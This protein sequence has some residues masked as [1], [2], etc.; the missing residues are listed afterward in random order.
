VELSYLPG[1]TFEGE[2]TYVYPFL[3]PKTRTA[4]VRIEL[5]N[6]DR[7]LKPDMFANVE[8]HAET[9]QGVL[10][11]PEA[12][13]IRSGRRTLVVVALGEGRFEP[14]EVVLGMDSGDGQLEIRE[15]L[16]ESE[17]IVTSGQFL[18]DSESKLQDAVQKMMEA[19]SEPAGK[20]APPRPMEMPTPAGDGPSPPAHPMDRTDPGEH[21]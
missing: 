17:R 13:V 6:P 14:R 2:V 18:I 21:E 1:R 20:P 12:A 16:A 9:L 5:E 19:D 11:V 8:I 10:T 15:G 3:D 4:R 7:I